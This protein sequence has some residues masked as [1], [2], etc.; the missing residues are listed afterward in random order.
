M[1]LTD[2]CTLLGL[3]ISVFVAGWQIGYRSGQKDQREED[4]QKK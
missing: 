1:S 4:R 2:F 3:L